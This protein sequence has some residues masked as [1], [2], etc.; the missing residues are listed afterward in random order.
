MSAHGSRYFR[1]KLYAAQSDQIV[2]FAFD[3]SV[4]NV[5]P[6]MI[7]RSVPGYETLITMIG[8]LAEHYAQPDSRCYDLGCS[9]GAATLAMQRRIQQRGCHI[10][11]IDNAAAMVAR[12][13]QNVHASRVDAGSACRVDVVCADIND[14]QI[15][16]ASLVVLNF[17]LQF[18]QPASRAALLSKIYRGLLPGGVLVLSEKIAQPSVCD[19]VRS[20]DGD[21]LLTTL[22]HAF[23]KANGYSDLEISQKRTALE[24]VLISDSF[25]SHLQRLAG[26]GFEQRHIWFQCLNFASMLAIK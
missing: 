26:A 1:D 8:L 7:R 19:G 5:F 25:D 13:K 24:N 22:H 23:K 6:D 12:C 20:D 10:V 3:E 17:T 21:D 14:V 11:A 16:N 4:A 9:L 18:F 15:E 2:D